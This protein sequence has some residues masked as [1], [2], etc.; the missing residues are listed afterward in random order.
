MIHRAAIPRIETI[1]TPFRNFCDVKR[2]CVKFMGQFVGESTDYYS[3]VLPLSHC[4]AVIIFVIIVVNMVV[5]YFSVYVDVAI[6]HSIRFGVRD[7]MLYLSM[8]KWMSEW[9]NE[10]VS[11]IWWCATTIIRASSSAVVHTHTV[12]RVY[13]TTAENHRWN[14]PVDV[15]RWGKNFIS[16]QFHPKL[17]TTH[18]TLKSTYTRACIQKT[19]FC[20]WEKECAGGGRGRRWKFQF[21]KIKIYRKI[22]IRHFLGVCERSHTNTA[23]DRNQIS[24]GKNV[25][26]VLLL[27]HHLSM[28]SFW[29]A[30]ARYVF[31]WWGMH[32]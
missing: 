3:M 4:Y 19:N 21:R 2:A 9:V 8:S 23:H 32:R 1:R 6:V 11:G 17:C 28:I 5:N 26:I 29:G 30:Y 20:V 22:W 24:A 31:F 14:H 25:L 13:A 16:S 12:H 18:I 27:P 7:K 15:I 10:S